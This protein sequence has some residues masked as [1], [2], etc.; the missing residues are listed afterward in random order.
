MKLMREI[1]CFPAASIGRD[2]Q[3]NRWAGSGGGDQ[4]EMYWT[5]RAIVSGNPDPRSGYLCNIKQIDDF[6]YEMVVPQLQCYVADPDQNE[7]IAGALH[8]VFPLA[9]Q[10]SPTSVDLVSLELH[11]S[12]Y[13][14]F[15]VIDGEKDMVMLTRS[16]EFSA[17]HRLHC[18]QLSDEENRSIF[19][20]CGNPHG[21]GHN[22]VVEVT[23]SGLPDAQTGVLIPMNEFDHI[24][25]ERVIARYDHKNLNI[26]CAEFQ[27]VNPSVEN[28]AK[29]IWDR[30]HGAFEQATLAHVRVWETPKTYAE[31]AGS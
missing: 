27:Q 13:T 12:P 31:Y 3:L 4:F 10:Q 19:G 29:T 15:I 17:A 18:E 2:R 5:L 30:L 1:R 7:G 25:Y 14:R 8:K 11:I 20:K 23:L 6:L 28:I 24:V 26:E 21:H 9:V 16:F 22:Y